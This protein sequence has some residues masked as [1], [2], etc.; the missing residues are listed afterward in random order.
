MNI[1]S[2]HKVEI[3]IVP[4]PDLDTS[5]YE[6]DNEGLSESE[7]KEKLKNKNK[8]NKN[9]RNPNRAA[10]GKIIQDKEIALMSAVKPKSAPPKPYKSSKDNTKPKTNIFKKLFRM[11]FGIKEEENGNQRPRRYYNK[12]R[13]YNNRNYK[14]NKYKSNNRRNYNKNTRAKNNQE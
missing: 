4:D 7:F 8:N 6:I 3:K 13:R 2:R 1:E 5:S 14:Y 10:D 12:N 9:S 11:I